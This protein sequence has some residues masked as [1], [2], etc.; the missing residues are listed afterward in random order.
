MRLPTPDVD[1]PFKWET[2][3]NLTDKSLRALFVTN[4]HM[5]VSP[6]ACHRSG[7]KLHRQNALNG[8]KDCLICRVVPA[9]SR[10]SL[11]PAQTMRTGLRLRHAGAHT[12]V[13][14]K[15][16]S[17]YLDLSL[18]YAAAAHSRKS[19]L[20]SLNSNHSSIRRRTRV[21]NTHDEGAVYE[22]PVLKAATACMQR[23]GYLGLML[24][25]D[26]THETLMMVTNSLKTDLN[27]FGDPYIVLNALTA[28]ANIC[29]AGMAADLAPEVERLADGRFLQRNGITG[30]LA[31]HIRKKALL[32]AC[33]MVTRAPDLE[34]TFRDV[35][36]SVI[37]D[38]N[39]AVVMAGARPCRSVASRDMFQLCRAAQFQP[40]EV[41]GSP[42][43][44]FPAS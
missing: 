5:H 28:L 17:M 30:A 13:A 31:G 36:G 21:P 23:V 16:R 39:H 43:L 20:L 19:I 41:Y 42:R 3:G 24:L 37:P 33:R 38:G 27:R 22:G 10:L 14:S 26:E 29:S 1:L 6:Y 2:R 44:R 18:C 40:G 35:P 15:Q 12:P 7:S 25:L 32:A 9:S 8:A 11:P 34:E 4:T